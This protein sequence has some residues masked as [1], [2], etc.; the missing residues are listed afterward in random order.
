M[1]G[2]NANNPPVDSDWIDV[3]KMTYQQKANILYLYLYSS[4]N[5]AQV[6]T[7]VLG[8]DGQA[9]SFLVSSVMKCY[10]FSG[11]NSGYF[12][13]KMA[14]N[15]EYNDFLDFVRI[16][17]VG[18]KGDWPNHNTINEFMKERHS[19]KINSYAQSNNTYYAT[20]NMQANNYYQQYAWNMPVSNDNQRSDWKSIWDQTGE[21]NRRQLAEKVNK[22]TNGDN[23]KQDEDVEGLIA[24]IISVIIVIAIIKYIIDHVSFLSFFASVA[25]VL[26]VAGLICCL[27]AFVLF[28]LGL[29]TGKMRRLLKVILPM[30]A[31][32]FLLA[33]IVDGEFGRALIFGLVALIGY[34][35]GDALYK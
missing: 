27:G 4:R 3:G 35:I 12:K 14:C 31:V 17:P 6:A 21:N 1:A 10:G 23:D 20:S 33:S 7:E 2:T 15:L 11:R 30:A 32:G 16:Y 24:V 28:I 25:G 8:S 19:Q 29:V 5:M 13:N 34:G 18:I 9:E 22:I 26:G